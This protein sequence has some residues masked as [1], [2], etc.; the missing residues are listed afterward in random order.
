M[1]KVFVLFLIFV[2]AVLL[3]PASA[4]A[5]NESFLPVSVSTV[6]EDINR[7]M[8]YAKPIK[9][10]LRQSKNNYGQMLYQT[11][12]RFEIGYHDPF[13]IAL[14]AQLSGGDQKLKNG[15]YVGFYQILGWKPFTKY[16]DRY[17]HWINNRYELTKPVKKNIKL[18]V[19]LLDK[20]FQDVWQDG[21]FDNSGFVAIAKRFYCTP[22]HYSEIVYECENGQ[23]FG[24]DFYNIYYPAADDAWYAK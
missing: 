7:S 18:A 13:M 19:L 5:S 9:Q 2:F 15:N 24:E 8:Q 12:A 1:K 23:Q 21:F 14:M 6:Q 3:S 17:G 11:L 22:N 10:V 4:Q 16:Q 20:I